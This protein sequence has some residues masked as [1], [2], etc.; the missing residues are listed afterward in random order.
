[1]SY[2]G[3]LPCSFA[4]SIS[5]PARCRHSPYFSPASSRLPPAGSGEAHRAPRTARPAPRARPRR[6]RA[7]SE[8]VADDDPYGTGVHHA[9][10]EVEGYG[11]IEVALNAN[12][13]PI[14]VSNFCH[15]ANEGFYD[16][17]TFH[18]VIEG[19]M[20]QG[21]DPAGTARR[22]RPVHQGEF[23]AKAASENSLPHTPR[24]HLLFPLAAYN[25]ASSQFFI[26]K[27]FV[28]CWPTAALCRQP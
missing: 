2:L 24:H 28:E 12:V 15:L 13:V 8:S 27:M 6:P 16:G 20:I 3:G 23:S 5:L 11:T 26:M 19:F 14:T 9:T 7:S 22:L 4:T 1:M 25:S 10:I 17:L 18:R 21:G